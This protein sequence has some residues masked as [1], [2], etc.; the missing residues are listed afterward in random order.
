MRSMN[1][2]KYISYKCIKC[3]KEEITNDY[4]T[5]GRRCTKCCGHLI[6][7]RYVGIDLATGKDK[8]VIN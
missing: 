8:C 2:M 5:D 3:N 1:D 4:H 6:A 7:T